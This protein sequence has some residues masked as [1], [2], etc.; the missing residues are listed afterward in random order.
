[1]SKNCY[2]R[3]LVDD[4]DAM[5]LDSEITMDDLVESARERNEL[6]GYFL[7]DHDPR[8]LLG[9]PRNKPI[10]DCYITLFH[11]HSALFILQYQGKTM[12]VAQEPMDAE[13][14]PKAQILM[15]TLSINYRQWLFSGYEQEYEE[16][17]D[18]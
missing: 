10:Q 18:F 11:D 2:A 9:L 1:M 12:L 14:L 16:D 17:G 7:L 3:R 4:I 13:D 6:S 8:K 15:A 5:D